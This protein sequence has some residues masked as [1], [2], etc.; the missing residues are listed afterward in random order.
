MEKAGELGADI[1]SLLHIA[2]TANRDFRRV[3]SPG[4]REVGETAVEVWKRLVC[5]PD[6]FKSVGTEALFDEMDTGRFPE[7]KP[8]WDYIS[9]RYRW[10]LQE[11]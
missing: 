9:E 11:R 7:M 3:T 5:T 1:V 6:R 10:V 2:P 8:W 4:L